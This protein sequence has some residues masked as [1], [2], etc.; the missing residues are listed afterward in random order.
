MTLDRQWGFI[1]LSA[2]AV[3]W[4]PSTVIW[5]LAG[6]LI[7]VVVIAVKDMYQQ[8]IGPIKLWRLRREA[9]RDVEPHPETAIGRIYEVY[10][11]RVTRLLS[12]FLL[13]SVVI[14]FAGQLRARFQ[15]SFVVVPGN[16]PKVI[17]RVYGDDAVAATAYLERRATTMRF[18]VIPIG[19]LENV[20]HR[21]LKHLSPQ[22]FP[23]VLPPHI[24]SRKSELKSE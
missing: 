6:N 3:L 9:D 22:A 8:K 14:F 21:Y 2:G 23:L 11:R 4:A 19:S 13:A 1:W 12:L 20:E 7:A 24:R 15:S 5:N 17:L 16:P 10:G 18:S